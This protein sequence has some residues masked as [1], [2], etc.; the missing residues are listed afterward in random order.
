[1]FCRLLTV[2]R[3]TNTKRKGN[4]MAHDLEI[5]NGQASFIAA[6]KRAWHGLGTIVDGAFSWQDCIA[7]VPALNFEVSKEQLGWWDKNGEY[8]DVPAWG[9]FRTDN[10]EFLGQVGNIYTPIQ[11]KYA[12]EMC[13]ALMEVENGAHYESAGVLGKGERFFVT[14]RMSHCD[15]HVTEGDKHE[16]YLLF[17]S[18]HDGSLSAQAKI[19][20]TRVV[21][22][23]TLTSAL[24]EQGVAARIKHTTS[25]EMKLE[26]AKKFMSSATGNIISMEEKF[27][28]LST[29][30][31]EKRSMMN[32]LNKLFDVK[33][34]DE[35][36]T[37][38]K[39]TIIDILDLYADN[40][41]N[42][43]PE[44][45]G[46]AYN[47]LNAVTNWSDHKRGVRSTGKREGQTED[48]LRS[49]SA[50]FGTGED[51]KRSALNT[52]L[53]ETKDAPIVCPKIYSFPTQPPP[54]TQDGGDILAGIL[55]Q[56]RAYN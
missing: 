51:F 25:A 32:V 20:T 16:S 47:L 39:N 55:G 36:G 46:T 35:I 9:I 48:Q 43:F 18:S 2:D 30:K 17:V 6:D 50:I 52:I 14:A 34:D 4:K 49:E 28:L 10:G 40:D 22:N 56:E 41:N 37:R 53:R 11:I 23:N 7:Q 33:I 26:Q 29:R 24:R 13:D 44:Q 38:K 45:K 12:F 8:Q 3:N 21:C 15:F 1:M 27:R 54:V 42:T 5:I 19:I 31:I